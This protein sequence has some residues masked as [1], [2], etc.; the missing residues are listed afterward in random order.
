MQIAAASGE[1][2]DGLQHKA[3]SV[4]PEVVPRCDEMAG[5][6]LKSDQFR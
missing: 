6:G 2:G 3:N 4:M 1:V 5:S